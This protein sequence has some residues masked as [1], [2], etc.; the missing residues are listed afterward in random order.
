[1]HCCAMRCCCLDGGRI[2]AYNGFSRP[3]HTRG[4]LRPVGDP[5]T[6]RAAHAEQSITGEH[7]YTESCRFCVEDYIRQS[8]A[9]LEAE[10]EALWQDDGGEGDG[11]VVQ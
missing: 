8:G 9:D 10:L 1:M 7:L 2:C 11:D 3:D 4:V 5:Y 6:D